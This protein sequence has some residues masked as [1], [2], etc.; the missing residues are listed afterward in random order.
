MKTFSLRLGDESAKKVET[1]ARNLGIPVNL[2]VAKVLEMYDIRMISTPRNGFNEPNKDDSKMP[3]PPPNDTGPEVY[4][5]NKCKISVDSLPG[6]EYDWETG[7]EYKTCLTCLRAKIPKRK[8][9]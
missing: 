9:C 6:R 4:V 3:S 5:C 1:S 7:E 8:K 2:Y